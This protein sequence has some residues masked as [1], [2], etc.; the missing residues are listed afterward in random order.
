LRDLRPPVLLAHGILS[1]D[2]F[3]IKLDEGCCGCDW[4][5]IVGDDELPNPVDVAGAAAGVNV[6]GA[7][8]NGSL[9]SFSLSSSP[10]LLL[11][12]LPPLRRFLL[13]NLGIYII[14]RHY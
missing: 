4:S 8:E 11:R 1:S 2:N 3:D 7:A 6:A 10:P 5:G 14:V 12:R 13:L 9:F